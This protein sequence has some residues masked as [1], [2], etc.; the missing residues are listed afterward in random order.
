MDARTKEIWSWILEVQKREWCLHWNA[1]PRIH[2]GCRVTIFLHLF[3]FLSF[4]SLPISHPDH[5]T[6]SFP[7]HLNP[8]IARLNN[9]TLFFP[10]TFSL[11]PPPLSLS[12]DWKINR[13][14]LNLSYLSNTFSTRVKP[15]PLS[16]KNLPLAFSTSFRDENGEDGARE[17]RATKRE[18]R[19]IRLKGPL[20]GGQGDSQ[21]HGTRASLNHYRHVWATSR[22]DAESLLEKELMEWLECLLEW[23]LLVPPPEP[24]V[25]TGLPGSQSHEFVGGAR[26]IAASRRCRLII[27]RDRMFARCVWISVLT[28]PF[29]FF[30]F[31]G[32]ARKLVSRD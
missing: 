7:I 8:T 12:L 30:S 25:H 4:S 28:E 17:A 21:S 2:E 29:L 19:W 32:F 14:I 11:Q 16:W 6:K 22:F 15:F 13:W 10:K 20:T 9:S 26:G 3:H 1:F 5:R 18:R 27:D 23:P 31:F 24:D